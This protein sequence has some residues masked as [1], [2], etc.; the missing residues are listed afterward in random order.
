[1]LRVTVRSNRFRA[2]GSRLQGDVDALLSRVT[3]EIEADWKGGVRVDTGNL[4][5]SI[6]TDKVSNGYAVQTPADYAPFEEFGTRHMRG[7]H[8]AAGAAS[9]GKTALERGAKGLLK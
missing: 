9:K 3:H 5:R 1:M 8:A 2:V 6:Q 4:R 7:S